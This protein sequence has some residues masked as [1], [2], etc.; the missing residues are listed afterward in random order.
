MTTGGFHE[1][2]AAMSASPAA[3][4]DER[5]PGRV[6]VLGS[7]VEGRALAA[8]F[9]AEGADQVNLFSVYG[10]ELDTLA[11]GS[12][13]LRGVGPVGTF[14]VGGD[15]PSIVAT[16]VLDRAVQDA[17]LVVVT[18]PVL[19]QRT[20][21]LVLAPHLRDG[22][23][24]LVIPGRTLAALELHQ[25]IRAG[26]GI[27]QVRL[28]EVTDL[29]FD[30]V[31]SSGQ[32]TLTRARAVRAGVYPVGAGSAVES[33]RFYLPSL[34]A[35]GSI[36]DVSMADGSGAVEV[37]ALL[38][39]GAAAPA[40][41]ESPP[42]GT[43]MVNPRSFRALLGPAQLSLVTRLWDE[44]LAVA[45]KVG[46]RDMPALTDVV[47][48]VAGTSEGDGVRGVPD[49]DTARRT[50]RDAVLGSLVPLSSLAAEVDVPVPLTDA[51]ISM[52]EPM[53]GGGLRASGRSL[54]ATALAGVSGSRLRSRISEGL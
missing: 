43:T 33:I 39:Q 36:L 24:I 19:K 44:R 11:A 41:A 48:S 54:G 7:G 15:S 52:A 45:G 12:I 18:G 27:A 37:P 8:W 25:A 38:A 30:I 35:A 3:P 9:L 29:P 22:Q 53:L 42:P 28:V 26:G 1:A 2:V 17:D 40:Q 50:V 46:V 49:S 4:V 31:E 16:S 14:R 10:D 5:A 32:I 23:T 34:E 6:T 20:Y 51:M 21:G 47:E 13:T